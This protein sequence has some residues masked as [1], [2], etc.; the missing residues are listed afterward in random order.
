MVLTLSTKKKVLLLF[1]Y[2]AKAGIVA[3]PQP[4]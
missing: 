3:V 1:C 2:P 4:L